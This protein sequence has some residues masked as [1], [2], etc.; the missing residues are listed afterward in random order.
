MALASS[1]GRVARL[2]GSCTRRGAAQ[3]L[4]P[5]RRASVARQQRLQV[6]VCLQRLQ[7]PLASRLAG[8]TACVLKNVSCFIVPCHWPAIAGGG[9]RQ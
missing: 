1:T 9:E 7:R 6:Q 2:S 3:A 5:A 4:K 8:R